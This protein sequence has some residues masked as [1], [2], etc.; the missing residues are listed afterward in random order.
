MDE[1]YCF[2]AES[3]V[4]T[5]LSYNTVRCVDTSLDCF[6]KFDLSVE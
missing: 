6:T 3:W 2:I 4:S 5:R 1:D